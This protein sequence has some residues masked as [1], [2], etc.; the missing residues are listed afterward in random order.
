M[1]YVF[2]ASSFIVVGHYFPD[3]FPSFW[4]KFD[5]FVVQGNLV[6]VREVYN[7]LQG[8]GNRPHLQNWVKSNKKIFLV[9]GEKETEFLNEIFAVPHFR[10]L[11][12][13]RQRLQGSPAAD[14]F[15]IASAKVRNACVVTEEVM[16]ENAAR[17]PNVCEHFRID[18]TNLEGFMKQEGWEF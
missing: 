9:P 4:K 17:I 12:S 5:E 10:Q 8:K 15:V 7:E 3:R 14:P 13:Q 1:V 18:W 6:S 11:V 16:K 2:D